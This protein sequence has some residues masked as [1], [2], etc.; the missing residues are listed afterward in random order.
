[1]NENSNG[2]GKMSVYVKTNNPWVAGPKDFIFKYLHYVPLLLVTVALCLAIAYVKVRYTTQIFKVQS[3]LLIQNGSGMA[4]GSSGGGAKDEQFEALFL[5][6]DVLNLS[7]E[8]QLLQSTPVLQRVAKDLG[9]QTTYYSRGNVRGSLIYPTFPFTLN[10]ISKDDSTK[11]LGFRIILLSADR[12]TVDEG[13]TVFHFGDTLHVG[14]ARVQLIR[15]PE[16]NIFSFASRTFEI[17][18]SPVADAAL[19]LQGSLKVV[20]TN[21]QSTILTL[22]FVGENP[23]LGK[24][25]LNTLMG[26]YDTLMVEDKNRIAG[27][28]LRFI[29]DRI[30][31]LN[32]TIKGVQ[33]A[34]AN[35]MVDNKVFDIDNQSKAYL[36]KMGDAAKLKAD[37]EVKI[38]IVNHLL[39]YMSDKKNIHEL[40][41]TNLGIEEPALTQMVF[42]YNRLTLEREKNIKT[43]PETNPLIVSIDETIDKLRREIYQ[44]L[45]NV[46]T[47]YTIA[48]QKLDD[49]ENGINA[50]VT[51]LP[52]KSLGLLNIER[53]QKILEDLLSL[54]L[55]KKLEISMS[56]A[57]TISNS[58]VVEPAMARS[59]PVSPD[60]KNIYTMYFLLGLLLPTGFVVLRELLQD[61]INGKPD[62][63]KYTSAPILGEIGHS[64]TEQALV[65]TQNSRRLISEQFRIIR[66][67]LQYM[68]NKVDKPVILVTSSFS[69]EGKSF[70][71]TN[72][73][74]VMALSGK[75]TVIMEF[76]IRKP[77]IL[78][79]L[80]LKRKM[81][82]TNYIIGK[83]S[84][85]ELLIKVNGVDDLYVIPCGPIP[86]NPSEILL[87]TR[88][89][90]LMKEVM[91]HF[92]VVIMDTAPIGL[93]SDAIALNRFAN[94]TLYITRQGYTFRKQLGLVED[95]YI[96][97]KMPGLCVLINDVQTEGFYGGYYGG[98]YGYYGGYGYGKQSDYFEAEGG[99]QNR[100]FS[101]KLRSWA[102]RTFR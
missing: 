87:D 30:F 59:E 27:N 19:W 42:E 28:T 12:Y 43:T 35:F 57:S 47:A 24:D 65:V 78:A 97:K 2:V 54:L 102:K 18:W 100:W 32:D 26:V 36:D 3:S 44:A 52:G 22:T 29:N 14:D 82:I 6:R 99:R 48:S 79:G 11:G 60:R 58:R 16:V 96:N 74:A 10:I 56:S 25:V 95:L 88:L 80:E 37:Q 50:H 46:R 38:D 9:L 92:D 5:T 13:K 81:G 72:M 90:E 49:V 71:S 15:H 51:T 94:C 53:R 34:L 4:G 67:N 1:M 86:P 39:G 98:G 83:A 61:K 45:L 20:Q 70:V 31:E 84:F 91:E 101:G 75:K 8:I 69:G 68:I 73:G 76:D 93:V 77:K 63:E 7:N 64:E 17:G 21:E 23:P 62:V 40:V 66:T 55:Q 85:N 33:G 41:P 89:D